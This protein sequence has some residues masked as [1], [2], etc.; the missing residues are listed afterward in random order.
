[1][2]LGVS[3]K[4]IVDI[5]N[6]AQIIKDRVT[7]ENIVGGYFPNPPPRYNRIPCPLHGGEKFN[8]SYNKKYFKCFV[9]GATG[10]VISLV[11]QYFN[12]DFKQ[13][14]QKLNAD[15]NVGLDF[16]GV[17]AETYKRIQ[18][19]TERQKAIREAREREA[20]A[21]LDRYH[22]ALDR[23]VSLD[24]AVRDGQPGEAAHDAAERNLATAAYLLDVEEI[25]LARLG[26]V[27]N[28]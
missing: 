12:L 19:E 28:S 2:Q 15:F 16:D 8:F 17:D 14:L 21:A 22:A 5:T 23:W 26:R 10:D 18:E 25:N 11:M 1:M 7:M 13:A 4:P 3:M 20:A 9:C 6:Y 27:D 24:R